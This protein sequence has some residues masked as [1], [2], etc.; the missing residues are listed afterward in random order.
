MAS[1]PPSRRLAAVL[2]ADVA[3]YSRLMERD[4][5][6]THLRVQ[7]VVG[8]VLEPCFASHAG[9]LINRTGDGVL[10][11]F[12]SATAA[13]RC[14]IEVQRQIEARN[15]P[16][17]SCDQIKF[18]IG[19]NVADILID[20]QDIAGG[21]VNLAARLQ[22]LAQPGGICISQTVKEQIQEDLGVEYVDGGTRRV[23]NIS[24]PVRVFQVLSGQRPGLSKLR[25]RLQRVWVSS[26]WPWAV[27]GLA[28]VTVGLL[29]TMR[30]SAP[31]APQELDQLSIAVLPFKSTSVEIESQEFASHLQGQLLMALSPESHLLKVKGLAN[32]VQA[33]D[34]WDIHRARDDLKARYAVVGEVSK[35]SGVRKVDVRLLDTASGAV[36]WGD[37]FEI[38]PHLEHASSDIVTKRLFAALPSAVVDLEMKRL[39][40]ARPSRPDSMDLVLLGYAEEISGT[41]ESL[42]RADGLYKRALNLDPRNVP[43]LLARAQVVLVRGR[44]A[45]AP[46]ESASLR[47]A[48]ELTRAA[49]TFDANCAASWAMRSQILAA[50]GQHEAAQ[51]AVDLASRISPANPYVAYVRGK[52]LVSDGRSR[53]V[54]RPFDEVKLLY[55]KGPLANFVELQCMARIYSNR[56]DDAPP[57]CE[58][59]YAIGGGL[60]ATRAL[61]AL[62]GLSGETEKAARAKFELLRL[63]PDSSI[64]TIKVARAYFDGK[65][66]TFLAQR[67]QT[68]YRGLKI[69]GLPD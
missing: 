57:A 23:K 21:G 62:Y 55:E 15:L 46:S 37:T 35:V 5:T 64:G 18:R 58:S 6:G 10:V 7:I 61:V 34:S 59:W 53:E 49:V 39:K 28:M 13:V 14:A 63:E 1:A 43:A 69:A 47:E 41:A 42:E 27:A 2:I 12:P 4:E 9:R 50:M 40:H 65:S 45:T 38:P 29:A 22:T 20:E 8:Q 48:E 60:S 32:D 31:D 67:E 30:W 54:I 56:L 36:A 44:S 51:A 26:R 16:V 68:Y 17:P 19:I 66:A 11:E 25:V 52:L 24:R 3:G 33:R